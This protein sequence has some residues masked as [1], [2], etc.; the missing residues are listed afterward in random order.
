MER[1]I[2]IVEAYIVD[3]TEAFHIMDGYPK[4]FDSKNHD[5][6]AKK[7]LKRAQG[8][9]ADCQ[10]AMCKRDDRKL[11]TVTLTTADGYQLNR[12]SDGTIAEVEPN[13]NVE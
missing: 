8:E 2:Y 5:N 6:D 9:F 1:R 13:A 12:W 10:G 3:S 11:Q 7:A 4:S